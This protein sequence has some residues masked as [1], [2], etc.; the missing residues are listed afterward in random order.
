MYCCQESKLCDQNDAGKHVRK[1]ELNQ[2][3]AVLLP[4]LQH[5]APRQFVTVSV[6]CV[7]PVGQQSKGHIQVY[8]KVS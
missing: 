2:T 1:S 8:T 5:E 3:V 4:L 6:P 7:P